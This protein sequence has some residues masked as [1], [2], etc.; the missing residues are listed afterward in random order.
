VESSAI[1]GSAEVALRHAPVADRFGDA[2]DELADSGFAL[3]GADFAVQILAGHDVG[4][5]H[6]PVFGDFD[7]FLLEDHVA[8]GV[9]DLGQAE[10]PFNFVVGGHAGLGEQAAE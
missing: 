1:V 2:G 10:I 4:G 5:G 9:G 8:L 3:G 6:G 7:V